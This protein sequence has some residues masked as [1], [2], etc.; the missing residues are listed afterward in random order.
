MEQ[1]KIEPEM[2]VD[3]AKTAAHRICDAEAR[4]NRRRHWDLRYTIPNY[5]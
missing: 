5:N 4:F 2:I 1:F 3:Q